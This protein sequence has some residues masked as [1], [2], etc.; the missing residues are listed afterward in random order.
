[1]VD[2]IGGK[3][4]ETYAGLRRNLHTERKCRPSLGFCL[5]FAFPDCYTAVRRK[6][7]A[8]VGRSKIEYKTEW[9]RL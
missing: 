4:D 7:V 3:L 2:D 1:V 6:T 9:I 5:E 8:G